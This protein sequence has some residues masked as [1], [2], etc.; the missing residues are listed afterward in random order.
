MGTIVEQSSE[1]SNQ[2]ILLQ[3]GTGEFEMLTFTLGTEKFGV[4]VAKVREIIRADSHITVI[5]NA[6]DRIIGMFKPRGEIITV[7]D[8]QKCLYGST[9]SIRQLISN[10]PDTWSIE[11][12]EL[13]L[14]KNL[15]I[16]G[17]NQSVQAWLVDEACEIIRLSWSDITPPSAVIGTV[18]FITGIY[19]H[20]D[21]LIQ[22]IDFES[23]LTNI[24]PESGLTVSDVEKIPAN[25]V[26]E[27]SR[28]DMHIYIADDSPLLNK[29]ISNSLSKAGYNV[30]AFTD[31]KQLYE[32]LVKLH[33]DGELSKCDMIITDIEMPQ[34]DGMQLCKLIKQSQIQEL[35]SI[36]VL[37]FSSLIDGPMIEKCKS[38]GANGAFSKPQIGNVIESIPRV[39][40]ASK[41]GNN[42]FYQNFQ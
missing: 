15:I 2:G 12:K 21:A 22:I 7:I 40:N 41:N 29:L 35:A 18:G 28:S 11:D 9:N 23:I 10:P 17:F 42:E 6:D 27:I 20:K 39:I 14:H 31:G 25:K 16:C 37:M 30:S 26:E 8:L 33:N 32:A 24:N 4:N 38:V 5:P 1:L 3:S 13:L 34:V 19:K 36:P